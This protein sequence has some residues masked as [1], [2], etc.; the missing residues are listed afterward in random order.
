MSSTAIVPATQ[1][2]NGTG[3]ACRI[4]RD[5]FAKKFEQKPPP[6]NFL[7]R[8]FSRQQKRVK[9]FHEGVMSSLESS[10]PVC[11]VF[12]QLLPYDKDGV[13][14]DGNQQFSFRLQDDFTYPRARGLD[15]KFRLEIYR[16]K[17][18]S[19]AFQSSG[20]RSICLDM[21]VA[22][23]SPLRSRIFRRP[24]VAD[25]SSDDV[26]TTLRLQMYYCILRGSPRTNNTKQG[27]HHVCYRRVVPM[28][29]RVLDVKAPGL[30][31]DV[32]LRLSSDI[33][34]NEPKL[35]AALSYVWGE[36]P[37]SKAAQLRT[38]KQ[39]YQQ[40]LS[41]I[42]LTRLPQ[43]LR[44][45]V[46]VARGLTIRYLWI[47]ALCIIQ[48]DT[49]D[50]AAQ[51]D[52]MGDIY[53]NACVTICASSAS[54]CNQG[55]LRQRNFP[56]F[57]I[58]YSHHGREDPSPVTFTEP[59]SYPTF[60]EEPI[61][62]RGWTFQ[63]TILSRRII[64]FTSAGPYFW[65]R[66]PS[67]RDLGVATPPFDHYLTH[68]HLRELLDIHGAE[69]PLSPR[70]RWLW[71]VTQYS[72]RVLK[73]PA[74]NRDLA[75]RGIIQH[76]RTE[77]G[78]AA[79]NVAGAWSDSLY[80]D[81]I[82]RTAPKG[83]HLTDHP[84]DGRAPLDTFPTW[85]W[86]SFFGQVEYPKLSKAILGSADTAPPGAMVSSSSRPSRRPD[87]VK[88]SEIKGRADFGELPKLIASIS[89]VTGRLQN[90]YGPLTIT[91]KVK[92]VV[93]PAWE[94][95]LT[96]NAFSDEEWLNDPGHLKLCAADDLLPPRERDCYGSA[97]WD[98][99]ECKY[100]SFALF[101]TR[102]KVGTITFDNY[103]ENP[104]MEFA[105][106]DRLEGLKPKV[107]ECLLIVSLQ[108][109]EYEMTTME[110]PNGGPGRQIMARVSRRSYALVLEKVEGAGKNVR[111]RVGLMTAGM[112][113]IPRGE[114][115][116][117]DGKKMTF[118]II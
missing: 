16:L 21:S 73:E 100:R 80:L 101:G 14:S 97:L 109:F 58:P 25:D 75:L 107:Y 102:D 118:E 111:R 22:H 85:S 26:F 54:G 74:L 103:S 117:N 114:E 13:I 2:G 4:C 90:G 19:S 45:A 61:H 12:L 38:T 83:R 18:S 91:G 30:G 53:T 20:E 9:K 63:E 29:L 72:Q 40:H 34:D 88:D 113:S 96:Y 92:K 33:P 68:A 46:K 43:S 66:T 41:R 84:T 86:M 47:D 115:Y 10:C 28:P 49:K 110:G 70:F 64:F 69:L 99:K 48:D 60:G 67:S 98:E 59:K 57:T 116:L 7:L 15:E 5:L 76:H 79:V 31:H 56:H 32:K 94:K 71:L 44:D 51:I 108:P 62:G 42:P 6:K 23:E 8:L 39:T 106:E 3:S 35:Y 93:V 78:G 95:P 50:M 55:F 82:W 36:D 104:Y 77:R 81:L 1:G 52:T 89:P 65:C 112:A 24:P 17:P 87:E 27:S 37:A 11:N 105:R